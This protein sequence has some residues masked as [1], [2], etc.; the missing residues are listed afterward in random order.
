MHPSH[1]Q[2]NTPENQY[3]SKLSPFTTA[4]SLSDAS[5]INIQILTLLIET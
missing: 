2:P 5:D 4:S 3:F 1:L